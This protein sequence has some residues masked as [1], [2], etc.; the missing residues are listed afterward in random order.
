MEKSSLI[1]YAGLDR[2]RVDLYRKPRYRLFKTL[3]STACRMDC[4][5]CPLSRYCRRERGF[6]R[7][8][9]L[10]EYFLR[11]YRAKRIDGFFLTSTLYGDPEVVVERELEVVTLLRK[12]GYRGYIH[13]RLMPGTPKD[14]VFHAAVLAD[15]VGLNVEAPRH[16]F[17]DIAPSKGDW[18]QDIVKRIEWL[19]RL[20]KSFRIT[21]KKGIGYLSSGIDT[22]FVL[23]AGDE[24]DLEVLETAWKLLKIGVD[25][26]Y[27]SPFKP[28]K[29]IPLE[30]RKP[31]PKWRG[32]RVT[33][34][35]ELMRVYGYTLDEIRGITGEDGMLSNIDPK[36]AYAEAH[37][38]LF[39][40]DLN[41]DPY[42]LIVRVPGIGP[43]TARKIIEYREQKGRLT[44]GILTNIM[45]F[46]RYL[47][48]RKYITL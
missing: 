43:A 29:G 38:D 3:L 4:K 15:R 31:T 41:N 46:K 23:G 9:E 20:K 19:A 21:S 42:E 45:G 28:Y 36:I 14:L 24:T 30:D 40:V 11:S 16:V 37:R 34:A 47:K 33:Q 6:W 25:K 22:Q 17:S 39:P 13:L 1:D 27:I 7:P 44:L 2:D 12:K 26:I 48:A 5:Y 32:L 18:L 10:V 8:G 35:I